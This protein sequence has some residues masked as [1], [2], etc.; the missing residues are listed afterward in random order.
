M[1]M[2]SNG[3]GLG[4]AGARTPAIPLE[5]FP[6]FRSQPQPPA[7]GFL[8]PCGSSGVA[9]SW[10]FKEKNAQQKKKIPFVSL[11]LLYPY[12]TILL[13]LLLFL[14]PS[15][16]LIV[17]SEFRQKKLLWISCWSWSRTYI[18]SLS[19]ANFYPKSIYP[20]RGHKSTMRGKIS[21]G[22]AFHIRFQLRLRICNS[23]SV[24]RAACASCA[25]NCFT[26]IPASINRI[27]LPN[28]SH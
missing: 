21:R 2:S 17:L 26:C 6:C 7:S 27:E 5:S 24:L 25:Q 19:I 3:E 11:K 16:S 4:I 14:F 22:N 1:K 9:Q 15:S 23:C 18:L 20:V 8:R 28:F 12:C 13:F 10:F